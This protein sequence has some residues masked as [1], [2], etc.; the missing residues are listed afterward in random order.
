VTLRFELATEADDPALRRLV[1]DNP[2]DG[3]IRVTLEREPNFFRAAAAEGGDHCTAVARDGDTGEIVAMGSRSV[4]AAFVNGERSRLGYLSQLRVSRAARTGI[5]PLLRGGY[6]LLRRTQGEGETPF[7][8]TTIIADNVAARR[9]LEAGLPRLPRYRAIEEIAT[10][11]MPVRRRLPGGDRGPRVV[12]G[13]AA[14][15]PGILDCLER[16]A[17]RHQF[18]VHW[19]AAG[20]PPLERFQVAVGGGRVLGCLALWDQRA[21][22]QAVVRGYDRGLARWRPLLNLVGAPLP[23]LGEPLAQAH[24]SHVAVDGDDA[25]VLAALLAAA[26]GE[27]RRA[28]LDYLTT[29]FAARHPL[30]EVVR[31]RHRPREYTS[32]LYA[33][34]WGDPPAL[35]GRLPHPEVA[36]L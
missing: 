30:A 29:G 34:H 23:A 7:D 18:A 35:D 28:G 21:F 19:T 32:V 15:L 8:I 22:K 20:L 24:L 27:A 14:A 17:R 25:G 26:V 11:L 10:F 16:F 12:P 1:R 5:R 31:R 9:L 6:D 13:S 2:M 33:V 3:R 36:V 4:R